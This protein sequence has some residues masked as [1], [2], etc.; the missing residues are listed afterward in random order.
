MKDEYKLYN[1]EDINKY[2]R[3]FNMFSRKLSIDILDILPEFYKEEYE[4]D[5][6]IADSKLLELDKDF[7]YIEI[8]RLKQKIFKNIFQ[9]KINKIS[10]K[11]F[12]ELE[13][14]ETLQSNLRSFKPI[15]GYANAV[16]YNQVKTI[17]G[18]LINTS[19]SPKILTLPA[20]HRKI[21][22]S[23]WTQEGD[24]LQVD[25]KSLEPRV[26]RKINGKEAS[27]DIYMDI[28]D[29]LDFKVDRL[30]IKRAIISILYG[31]NSQIDGLSK[32]R[33][34]IVLRATREYFDIQSI[35]NKA[36]KEYDV[37]CR[38]NFYG[39]PIWNIKESKENKIVNNYVQSTA[40]DVAL[41]YFSELCD[42]LDLDLCKPIFIIHDALIC[43]VHKDYKNEFVKIVETGFN[44]PKLGNFPVEI[45][46]VLESIYE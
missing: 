44:C 38:S 14:N 6:K 39:R 17:S 5:I 43:D 18:R 28:A 21:F 16:E 33:S 11:V 19:S 34:D 36:S 10:Y 45:T 25:F 31:S 8:F 22:E 27:D 7:N 40:V 9:A 2:S 32:E 13:K 4:K 37:G 24:L 15:R 23:R 35:L 20:R 26:I 29:Q 3:F 42:K 12:K 46:N 41:L 1:I 30:I